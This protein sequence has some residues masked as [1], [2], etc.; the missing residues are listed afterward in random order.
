MAVN[1]SDMNAKISTMAWLPYMQQIKLLTLRWRS[2]SGCGREHFAVV[3]ASKGCQYLINGCMQ[4]IGTY[5]TQDVKVKI[6]HTLLT[7]IVRMGRWL[8]CCLFCQYKLPIY[9]LYL[10]V[11]KALSN[12]RTYI[13]TNRW[14]YVD[15]HYQNA[16]MTV[17]LSL[18]PIKAANTLVMSNGDQ[19]TV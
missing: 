10:T 13:T 8:W 11:T 12:Y 19:S 7:L 1:N 6:G 14:R 5:I 15:A 18:E 3:F 4:P 17:L 2:F 16:A 9:R